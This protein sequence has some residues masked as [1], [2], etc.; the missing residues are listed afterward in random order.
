MIAY[1][2]LTTLTAAGTVTS[3]APVS[4][5]LLAYHVAS[6][7]SGTVSIATTGAQPITIATLTGGAG[8][9]WYYPRVQGCD[10]GGTAISGVYDTYPLSGYVQAAVNAAGTVT[11]TLVVE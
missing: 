10:V 4:G 7:S 1:I 9:T 6:N 2:G 11:V 5:E 8:T 3:D